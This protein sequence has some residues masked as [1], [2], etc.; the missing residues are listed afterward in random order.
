[1]LE[2]FRKAK[3]LHMSDLDIAVIGMAGIFAGGGTLSELRR[4]LRNGN[5][6][7]SDIKD[8]DLGRRGISARRANFVPR[9]GSVGDL[10]IFDNERL[11]MPERSA[12]IADPQLRYAMMVAADALRSAG[13]SPGSYSGRIG[14]FGGAAFS[15]E[16]CLAIQRMLYASPIDVEINDLTLIERD[17][18]MTR[19]AYHLGLTGPAVTV[20]TTCSTSLVAVHLAVQSL[21]ADDSDIVL[22]GGC[23]LK[24][25]WEG[26]P[27]REG[28]IF[29]QSGHCRPFDSEAD[30]T[31]LGE[32]CGF[33]ALKRLEE[34]QGDG[35]TI[36]AI[37]KGS[38]VNNDGSD[39]AGYAA[40]SV[41]GQAEVVA[42]A[43]EISAIDVER[44]AFVECHGTGT[45]IGDPIEIQALREAM[46]KFGKRS[47][48]YVGSVKANIG[49]ADAAAGIAGLIKAILALQERMVYPLANFRHPNPLCSFGDGSIRVPVAATPLPDGDVFASVSSFGVGGTNCHV[50]VQAHDRGD[51]IESWPLSGRRF[52]QYLRVAAPVP[53]AQ[54]AEPI[55]PREETGRE[56]VS[57][58]ESIENIRIS[59]ADLF[60]SHFSEHGNIEAATIRDCGG[61]SIMTLVL[62]EELEERFGISMHANEIT[63]DTTIDALT[64]IVTD[65]LGYCASSGHEEP[66]A[67][68]ASRQARAFPPS[69]GGDGLAWVVANRLDRT[70][71]TARSVAD[72][73]SSEETYDLLLSQ[74]RFVYPEV[75]DPVLDASA[76][77]L[78]IDAAV[79]L[80][81]IQAGFERLVRREIALRTG[82]Q[83]V[84]GRWVCRADDSGPA[85]EI[86]SEEHS[87]GAAVEQ[88]CRD[89]VSAMAFD[90]GP[91]VR[92]RL[93]DSLTDRP[94][95]LVLALHHAI[96]D[97]VSLMILVADLL[98][99]ITS[100]SSSAGRE[101]LITYSR[102]QR[103]LIAEG[104]FLGEEAYWHDPL[105]SSTRALPQD[106]DTHSVAGLM[107][108]ELVLERRIPG[109][110]TR[111]LLKKLAHH[112]IGLRDL[113]LHGLVRSLADYADAGALQ[114]MCVSSGRDVP[115]GMRNFDFSRTIGNLALGGLLCLRRPRQS[116]TV[117]A[118]RETA[119]WLRSVPNDGIAQNLAGVDKRSGFNAGSIQ[120]PAYDRQILFNFHGYDSYAGDLD[121]CSTMR[122]LGEKKYLPSDRERWAKLIFDI[123]FESGELVLQCTYSMEQYRESTIGN[124]LRVMSD[125]VA[126]LSD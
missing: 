117:E 32:G 87:E 42:S 94:R 72:L 77:V 74:V 27:F 22:A 78:E 75:V 57:R 50:V 99:E 47:P 53:S 18:Y 113:L 25:F 120:Y 118:V 67:G 44:L 103:R 71:H 106:F 111:A 69:T 61:D 39:K 14:I 90:G 60:Q 11:R 115:T 24:P 70:Q 5:C 79:P 73:S 3:P 4:D 76:H 123:T 88:I 89:L 15:I 34:A 16:W 9:L 104:A 105:W 63:L 81:R 51:T 82:F 43:I 126:Q 29:S 114:V 125:T 33:V 48:L 20:N 45:P 54:P 66:R 23:C 97:G 52:D 64:S 35:D 1:L 17:F 65:K 26:Y 12:Q 96:Y 10:G 108:E 40:P 121:Q 7:V 68:D 38:A 13:Y 6:L 19:I 46:A 112:K 55:S 86:L 91:L 92:A 59:V 84:G 49:H 31:V 124:L 95:L 100:A 28:G 30:G 107:G 8:R 56:P 116:S 2:W 98:S 119:R 109:A 102:A 85:L 122:Y 41:K 93:I 37:I 80:D 110:Q 58:S 21:L 83:L 36:L 62:A 101:T